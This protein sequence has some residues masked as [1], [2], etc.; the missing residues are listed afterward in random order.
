MP[1]FDSKKEVMFL[2]N[3][4]DIID[5]IKEDG[6]EEVQHTKTFN[7]IKIKLEEYW[8]GFCTHQLYRISLKEVQNVKISSLK[9]ANWLYE[10]CTNVLINTYVLISYLL[11]S[12][13]HILI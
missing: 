12:L 9:V 7:K 1:C 5:N 4:W 2:T 11:I 6:D 8:P 13:L 3:Q 10:L